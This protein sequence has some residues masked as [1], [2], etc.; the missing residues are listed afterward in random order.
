M[1]IR[2]SLLF[3]LNP[4]V[5]YFE[6]LITD[7][8]NCWY[9]IVFMGPLASGVISFLFIFAMSYHA[10]TIIWWTLYIMQLIL[11][12]I[13]LYLAWQAGY[14]EDLIEKLDT[15]NADDGSNSFDVCR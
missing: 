4:F 10:G 6:S 14:L 12:V 2:G 7:V 5:V 3:L 1:A 9:I 15:L 13:C 8:R 11:I